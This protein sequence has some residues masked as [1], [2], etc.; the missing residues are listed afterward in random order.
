M[1]LQLTRP[2]IFLDIESTGLD[3]SRD[4]IIEICY[5]RLEPNGNEESRTLRLRPVDA[6]GETVHIPTTSSDIHGITD[7]DVADCPTF[8]EEAPRLAAAFQHC[9]FAGFNSNRFDIPILV[10]HFL[11]AGIAIDFSKSRMID[12]QNIYH[13]LERRTLSAAYQYYCGKD[14]VNAHS[15]EADTRATLEVLE[16]QLDR[17]PEELHNDVG[18]LAEFSA[19][20]RHVDFAG[21]L[22]YDDADQ[23]VV[24]FGKHKGKLLEE[25]LRVEPSFLNWVLRGDFPLETKQQFQRFAFQ[26]RQP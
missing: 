4:Y 22:V 11:R 6:L 12:V 1:K 26:F 14:L 21:R 19:M 5:I 25:V 24:N 20:N 13:K 8:A 7:A 2:L 3:V 15:A 17:Y 10:E 23:P 9:D 16:A 18:F